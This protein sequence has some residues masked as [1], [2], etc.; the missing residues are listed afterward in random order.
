MQ[1]YSAYHI[2]NHSNVG[3]NYEGFEQK[4][5]SLPFEYVKFLISDCSN[6]I[7]SEVL[8]GLLRLCIISYNFLQYC[9]N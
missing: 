6:S 7:S 2:A 5:V 8:N 1:Y 3:F 4:M 9:V